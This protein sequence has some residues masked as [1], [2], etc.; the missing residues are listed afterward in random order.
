MFTEKTSLII[1]TRNRTKNIQALLQQLKILRLK[2]LEIII[3]DSSDNDQKKIIKIICKNYNIKLINSYPST[4]HQRNLGIKNKRKHSKFTMFLDDDLIF[5]KNSFFEMNKF[6]KNNDNILAYSFNHFSKFNLNFIERFKVSKISRFFHLYSNKPGIVMRS[7]WHTKIVN[8]KK[9]TYVEWVPTA[10]VIFKSKF[11]NNIRFDE[12]FG[13][14]SYLEDL[15]FSLN[16]KKNNNDFKFAIVSKAKFLHPNNLNRINFQFG[17]IEIINRFKIVKK[18]NLNKYYYFYISFIK[19]FI[20]FLYI[21]TLNFNYFF[22]F[23]GNIFG[24]I[25]SIGNISIDKKK[26]Y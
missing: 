11:I 2:F 23:T 17:A 15:D 10:A 9:N 20:S 25:K 22:K 21:F 26:N 6:I 7:G 19:T 8:L 4:S 14:Y 12:S 16:L 24:I 18:Y 5:Y 13:Q 3:V 1:P